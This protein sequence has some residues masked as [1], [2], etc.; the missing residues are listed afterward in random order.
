MNFNPKVTVIP[1]T[2]SKTVKKV[3]IYCRV[4]TNHMEQLKSLTAQAAFLTRMVS[5]VQEWRL[6]DIYIDICSGKAKTKRPEFN[7]MLD[8]C[9]TY[10]IEH[11]HPPII[12]YETFEKTKKEKKK[13][14]NIEE[15]EGEKKRKKTKYSFKKK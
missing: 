10:L 1:A 11:H 8:D 4:S 9:K 2:K 5:H 3:G 14:S 12:S 7:R 15:T 6:T 13:R